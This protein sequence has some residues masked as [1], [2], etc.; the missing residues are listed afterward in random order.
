MKAL[1]IA[2]GVVAAIVAVAALLLAIGI[3]VGFLTPTI[4]QRVERETGYRLTVKGATMIALWPSP[5]ITMRDVTLQAPADQD[6]GNR[7]TIGSIQ[8]DM[9]LASLWSGQPDITELVIDR[10]AASIP[11][12][13]QRRPVAKATAASP[14]PTSGAANARVPTIRRVT[15]SDG[16]IMLFNTHDHVEDHIEGISARAAIGADRHLSLDGNAR[17]GSH[18][19][20][21]H[22]TASLPDS[23]QQGQAIPAQL[24]LEAPGLLQA[25]LSS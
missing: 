8:A 2:G 17:A 4:E 1:K 24:T 13:R 9:T 21:F 20:T 6:S 7:L 12:H 14:A 22:L 25:P 19:L 11:L 15:V 16:S 10:P 23:S 18:P 5:N 3:P